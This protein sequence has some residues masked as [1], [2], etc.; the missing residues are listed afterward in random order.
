M[1]LLM[2]LPGILLLL[3][4]VGTAQQL[5]VPRIDLGR[6]VTLPVSQPARWCGREMATGHYGF[7]C[8]Q[9]LKADKKLP[10]PVRLR[11]G[12]MQMTDWLE[13]KPNAQKPDR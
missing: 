1:R 10:V 11:L 8:R 7:F 12:S 5:A 2:V 4:V 13:S 9:E 6:P 3:P